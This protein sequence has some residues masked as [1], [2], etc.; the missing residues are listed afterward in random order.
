M[1]RGTL[2]FVSHDTT[3][4]Q[5]LCD[6]ALLLKDGQIELLS[7]PKEV[8]KKYLTYLYQDHQDVDGNPGEQDVASESDEPDSAEE[9]PSTVE[10]H[11]MRQDFLNTT[12]YRNDI[13]L[14][15]FKR[16]SDSFGTG[17]AQIKDVQILDTQDRPLT[18]IVGGELVKL[19]IDVSARTVLTKPIVGFEFKNRLGQTIFGEN[20][21]LTTI[22]NDDL[23]VEPDQQVTAQFEFRLPVMPAGD[24][25]VAV[26]IADGEQNRHVQHQ[27]MHD[28]LLL[29]MHASSVC[30]G[31]VTIPMTAVNIW[32]K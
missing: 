9:A 10:P 5:S 7:R 29:R 11:D 3:S 25:S 8:S 19:R 26:A 1:E 22:D 30:F 17:L 24:Y 32:V 16:D 13:E 28:A 14:F 20:T 27:W 21:F 6:K 15:Q 2:L 23:S 4:V 12:Q 18:W 31:V